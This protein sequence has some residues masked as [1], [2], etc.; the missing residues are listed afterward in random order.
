[1]NTK[2]ED[3]A[4]YMVAFYRPYPP[5]DIFHYGFFVQMKDE[6]GYLYHVI[7]S[8]GWT[9]Q[10]KRSNLMSLLSAVAA[11]K[12]GMVDFSVNRDTL[13]SFFKDVL[14]LQSARCPLMKHYYNVCS[15]FGFPK[16]VSALFLSLSIIMRHV[17]LVYKTVTYLK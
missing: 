10:V 6:G 12:I 5:G 8:P 13:V 16:M 7:Q 9:F 14:M 1:M 17:V 4:I 15:P 2:I 11:I 3:N